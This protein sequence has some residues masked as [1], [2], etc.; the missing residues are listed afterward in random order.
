M[1]KRNFE[2]YDRD[3][4]RNHHDGQSN[5]QGRPSHGGGSGGGRGR[6]RGRGG[7]GRRAPHASRSRT[8]T[9]QMN[10]YQLQVENRDGL[11]ADEWVLY[12]VEIVD[13]KKKKKKG[14]DGEDLKPL[15]FEVVP[16]LRKSRTDDTGGE[17]TRHLDVSRGDTPRSRRVLDQLVTNLFESDQIRLVVSSEIIIALQW[18]SN[19]NMRI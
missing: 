9:V 17:S 15:Q 7:G 5:F 13:A 19:S 12:D 8:M 3:R 4:G 16:K 11:A 1:S 14:P 18:Y 10:M 2:S 6:G